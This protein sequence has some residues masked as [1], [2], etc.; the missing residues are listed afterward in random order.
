[1][2]EVFSNI[3]KKEYFVD[4]HL[5]HNTQ[6]YLFDNMKEIQSE[7]SQHPSGSIAFLF[8]K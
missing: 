8:K 6:K 7:R 5:D 2:E 4:D 1:M 3:M